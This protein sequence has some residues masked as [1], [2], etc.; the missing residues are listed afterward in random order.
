MTD[1]KSTLRDRLEAIRKDPRVSMFGLAPLF[2]P[3]ITFGDEV[4]RSIEDQ[5]ARLAELE[6]LE[7]ARR[8]GRVPYHANCKTCVCSDAE[9]S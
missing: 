5:H 7:A 4:V 8:A 6:R 9:G 1:E 3:L 2:A